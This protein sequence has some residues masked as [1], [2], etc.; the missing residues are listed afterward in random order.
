MGCAHTWVEKWQGSELLVCGQHADQ[1]DLL[2]RIED[3][4]VNPRAVGAE[5]GCTTFQCDRV[6]AAHLKMGRNT[7]AADALGVIGAGLQGMGQGSQ[8]SRSI[9]T[10]CRSNGLGGYNCDSN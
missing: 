9:S 7:T 8:N 5:D 6:I 3:A 4:C 1:S 2:E 10:Q